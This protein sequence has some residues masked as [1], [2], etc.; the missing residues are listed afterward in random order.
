MDFE[1]LRLDRAGRDDYSRSLDRIF[2]IGGL[3]WENE[4]P[5]ATVDEALADAEEALRQMLAEL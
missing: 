1:R 2:D 3:P 5:Y 4:K